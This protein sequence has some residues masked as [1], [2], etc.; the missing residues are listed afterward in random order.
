M[1]LLSW[2]CQVCS[3][4]LLLWSHYWQ[5]WCRLQRNRSGTSTQVGCD[6]YIH[7]RNIHVGD[8]Y[9]HFSTAFFVTKTITFETGQF[10]TS[11]LFFAPSSS[12]MI[13]FS[14]LL[15]LLPASSGHS[16]RLPHCSDILLTF[17]DQQGSFSIH[18]QQAILCPLPVCQP[19][20]CNRRTRKLG[21]PGLPLRLVKTANAQAVHESVSQYVGE[22]SA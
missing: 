2:L 13:A 11:K 5:C 10:H 15:T 20:V 6:I 18:Y 22:G 9:V 8:G 19:V 21:G 12:K 3:C 16:E 7:R 4:F 14:K 17:S 1:L